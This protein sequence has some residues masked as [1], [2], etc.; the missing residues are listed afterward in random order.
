MHTVF[1]HPRRSPVSWQWVAAVWTV[2]AGAALG[3]TLEELQTRAKSGDAEALTALADRQQTGI[4]APVDLT[5]AVKGYQQAAAK[6]NLR[7]T[8]RL[9]RLH[10]VGIAIDKNSIKALNCFRTAAEGGDTDA[11]CYLG[12]MRLKGAGTRRDP[13]EA[14]SWFRKAAEAG[15]PR[16]MLNLSMALAGTHSD[17]PAKRAARR[18]EASQWH[19][20]ARIK[21]QVAA[22][23]GD[24]ESMLILGSIYVQA[25]QTN[26]ANRK[27][28]AALYQR[29]VD[30]GS[31]EAMRLFGLLH[32]QKRTSGSLDSRMWCG[33]ASRSWR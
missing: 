14:I 31:T 4:G 9:G 19:D 20:K 29:A 8:T 16:G 6:G 2:M 12:M 22:D 24:T 27:R 10:L 23:S 25:G 15:N 33:S 7:A 11:M 1:S 5:A 28:G 21:L 18:K 17:M 3:E 26:E 30:L 32:W 13:P